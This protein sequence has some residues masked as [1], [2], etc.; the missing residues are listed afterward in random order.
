[1]VGQVGQGGARGSEAGHGGARRGTFFRLFVGNK[2]P[3]FPDN[4]TADLLSHGTQ[5]CRHIR[6]RALIGTDRQQRQLSGLR[7][8]V[9]LPG[10]PTAPPPGSKLARPA[11]RRAADKGADIQRAPPHLSGADWSLY[12]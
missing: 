10:R 8:L 6:Y 4:R 11:A 7:A 5:R 1:V 12:G 9:I 2:V 3:A